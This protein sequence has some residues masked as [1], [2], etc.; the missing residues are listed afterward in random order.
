MKG[1]EMK[2]FGWMAL[3]AVTVLI[4]YMGSRLIKLLDQPP[5]AV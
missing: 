2:P 3:L 4:V 5:P 1:W